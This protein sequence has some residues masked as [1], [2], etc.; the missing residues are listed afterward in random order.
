ML[1]VSYGGQDVV[2]GNTLAVADTQREPN[3]SFLP[4]NPA[5]K[6]TLMLV[7]PDAPSRRDPKFRQWRHWVKTNISMD[8]STG[9][10]SVR[11][12]QTLTS[13]NGP[14]PPAGSGPHRYVFLLYK[15]SPNSDAGMLS[16]N[17]SENRSMFKAAQFADQARLQLVGA[18]YFFAENK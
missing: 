6:Y 8:S 18:N 16:T 11:N 12:G 10:T 4:D 15:Q 17:M 9:L 7:D 3:V 13:Y 5:D 1:M 2:L 14:S